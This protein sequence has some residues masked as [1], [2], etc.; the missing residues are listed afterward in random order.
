MSSLSY[1]FVLLLFNHLFD[2]VLHID[3]VRRFGMVKR[4]RL[5]G[6]LMCRNFRLFFD[7]SFILDLVLRPKVI[8]NH[9]VSKLFKELIFKQHIV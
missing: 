1:F 7:D 6:Y 2:V 9:E 4:S 3:V 5:V 8:S